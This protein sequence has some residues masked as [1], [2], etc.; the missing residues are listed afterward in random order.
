M[1]PEAKSTESVDLTPAQVAEAEEVANIE[2]N[3]NADQPGSLSML[4]PG[5][6]RVEGQ[7][8]EARD[9]ISWLL[10][11][12]PERFGEIYQEYKKPI[13]TTGIALAAIPFLVLTLA[14][15]RMINAIPLFAPT[16]ELIGFGYASWFVYRY[17]LFAERRQ[18]LSQEYQSL[19]E[20]ILGQKQ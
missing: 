7:W 8:Q 4:P 13:T 11:V 1:N 9:Q 17:L 18:E 6:E 3:V 2:M 19:R 5:E 16:F 15:L 20:R 10:T 12:L 14:L